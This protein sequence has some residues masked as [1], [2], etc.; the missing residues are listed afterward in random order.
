VLN[1]IVIRAS[2]AR[3]HPPTSR[4]EF[5]K[6]SIGLPLRSAP[7]LLYYC[8]MN[9]ARALLVAK[10]VK[11]NEKHGISANPKV[12]P[13]AKRTFSMEGIKIHPKGI[14]P[15]LSAYYCE[16]ETSKT[17][18]LQELFLAQPMPAAE[19]FQNRAQGMDAVA[20][21]LGP[22]AQQVDRGEASRP[23]A[24]RALRHAAAPPSR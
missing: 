17:H 15:S 13:G 8:F 1:T 11:L 22:D 16:A 12:A 23:L 14:L 21:G 6:V 19:R 3:V 18:T 7:L 10:G 24:L 5:H 9:A 4:Q 20:A 2:C